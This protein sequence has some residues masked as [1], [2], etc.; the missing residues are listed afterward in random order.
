MRRRVRAALAEAHRAI[1][2]SEA[3][4]A[5]RALVRDR[6]RLAKRC[7]WCGR[8]ELGDHWTAP[9]ELPAFL[10]SEV[11]DRISHGICPDCLARLEREGQTR[12]LRR[13]A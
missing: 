11:R 9:E 12:S 13:P 1:A 2:R 3:L 5:A 7:A 8:L 4:T 6:H 10:S